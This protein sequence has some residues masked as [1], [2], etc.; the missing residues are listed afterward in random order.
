MCSED[1]D[2]RR[3]QE[4]DATLGKYIIKIHRRSKSVDA[5]LPHADEQY[6][7]GEALESGH[8]VHENTTEELS[9]EDV[10]K[11]LKKALDTGA[12]RLVIVTPKSFEGDIPKNCAIVAGINFVNFL[13][14]PCF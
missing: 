2:K 9:V 8:S 7:Y 11:E 12:E 5:I 10:R 14:R 1:I 6:K 3:Y 13:C 4:I